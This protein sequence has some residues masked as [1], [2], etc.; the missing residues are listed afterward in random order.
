MRVDESF[1]A[2]GRTLTGRN[3]REQTDRASDWLY[4]IEPV[5]KVSTGAAPRPEALP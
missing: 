5:W 4:H 3:L 1:L 2:N